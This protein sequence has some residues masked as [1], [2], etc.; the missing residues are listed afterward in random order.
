ME[1]GLGDGAGAGVDHHDPGRVPAGPDERLHGTASRRAVAD[2]HGMVT[3]PLPPTPVQDH[4][5][6]LM[7]E[8]LHRRPNQQHEEHDA[9]RRD[10]HGIHHPGVRCDRGDVPVAGRRD[11]HGGVVERIDQRD[12]AVVT[13]GVGGS[14]DVDDG[15]DGRDETEGQG[16]PKDQRAGGA[17]SR[18]GQ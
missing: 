8:H 9:Q 15:D 4:P 2:H 11:G 7:G 18:G 1:V 17:P 12:T 13:V 14:I 6:A 3:K 5:P 10:E 16:H